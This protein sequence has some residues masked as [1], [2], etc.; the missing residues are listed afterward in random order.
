MLLGHA[1]IATIERYTAVDGSEMRAAMIAGSMSLM[2]SSSGAASGG[3]RVLLPPNWNCAS[4]VVVA[5]V[6]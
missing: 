4:R 6:G 2:T 3:L 1:S 5:V